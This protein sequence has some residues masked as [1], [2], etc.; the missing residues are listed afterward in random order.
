MV[1][2][3]L[4]PRRGM[5]GGL[6]TSQFPAGASALG[7]GEAAAPGAP[8]RPRPARRRRW[9]ISALVLVV[10]VAAL[11]HWVDLGAAVAAV[12]GMPPGLVVVALTLLTADRFLMAAKWAHLVRVGGGTLP[13]PRAASIYYQTGF[14]N[15]VLP[16]SVASELLRVYLARR[17]GLAM[18]LLLAS[19]AVERLVAAAAALALALA[20]AA[21][22]IHGAAPQLRHLLVTSMA[23][24]VIGAA[25]AALIALH[26]PTRGRVWD[27][28]NRVA[29]HRLRRPLAKLAHGLSAY[30]GRSGAMLANFFLAAAEQVLGAVVMV[31]LARAV[32]I[33]LPALALAEIALVATF[34]RRVSAQLE[35][36][37][38]AEATTVLTY[39]L[40]GIAPERAVALG[41]ASYASYMVASLPGVLL[42]AAGGLGL[43]GLRRGEL[44][45]AD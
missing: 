15:M 33:T 4:H 12:G 32:G 13:V 34:V 2:V 42:L 16:S 39:S 45:A 18:P 22:L 5:S 27:F 26:T 3:D 44:P 9:L 37:G 10:V 21:L 28:V 41:L 20:G 29:P 25:V 17:T 43:G 23:T 8:G 36:W 19:M 31:V 35:S 14:T 40:F 11:I 24:A 1:A 30:D 7:E 6:P 38:L